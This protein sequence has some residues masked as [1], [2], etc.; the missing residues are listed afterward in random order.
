MRAPPPA[1]VAR[2]ES[3]LAARGAA[4]HWGKA[5]DLPPGFARPE[6]AAFD[7]VAAARGG[8]PLLDPR[9]RTR[10]R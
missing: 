6:L 10:W 5:V 2:V 4:P 8:A 7:A 1:W 9:A 3:A